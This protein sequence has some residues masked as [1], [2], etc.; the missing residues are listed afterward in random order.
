MAFPFRFSMDIEGITRGITRGFQDFIHRPMEWIS[1]GGDYL[2][3]T[4]LRHKAS[5]QEHIM[6]IWCNTSALHVCEAGLRLPAST[7]Q[8]DLKCEDRSHALYCKSNGKKTH[9]FTLD[10]ISTEFIGTPQ[11]WHLYSHNLLWL[12]VLVGRISSPIVKHPLSMF[13]NR[14]FHPP[15]STLLSGA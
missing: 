8:P 15:T 9:N 3:L 14:C 1:Y 11:W 7:A 4:S 13:P 5:T 2:A 10:T 12:R 6:I